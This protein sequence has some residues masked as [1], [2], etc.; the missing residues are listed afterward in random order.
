MRVKRL[1]D[2]GRKGLPEALSVSDQFDVP[3]ALDVIVALCDALEAE[4]NDHQL[5]IDTFRQQE[6]VWNQR[7]TEPQECDKCDLCE[8]HHA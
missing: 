2:C 8:D 3:Q 7:L 6:R 5:T 1:R 4:Q